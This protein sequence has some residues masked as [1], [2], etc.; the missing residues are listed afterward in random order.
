MTNHVDRDLGQSAPNI[1]ALDASVLRSIDEAYGVRLR[2][3]NLLPSEVDVVASAADI[4]GNRYVVKISDPQFEESVRWQHRMLRRLASNPRLTVP[5][6]FDT[7]GGADIARLSDGRFIRLYSWIDGTI[8]ARLSSHSPLLL[9]DL[10]AAAAEIVNTLEGVA[11]ENGV[12]R[13]HV[14]DATRAASSVAANLSAV[15]DPEVRAN[16][17]TI[18]SWFDRWAANHLDD[19][20]RSVVHQDLNDHNVL[21]APD[22]SGRMR[23]SG[24]LDF[25][26]ALY[27]ATVGEVAVAV[28]YAMPR[29]TDP[30]AAAMH[31]VAGYTARRDLSDA[32]LAALYPLAAA[33]LCVNAVIW[34]ART[35][36]AD[37]PYGEDRRRHTLP[38][39]RRVAAIPPALAEA[40][41]RYAAGRG[42]SVS[43]S[44]GRAPH[45]Q[46]LSG[47]TVV[48]ADL[49]PGSGLFDCV[50]VGEDPD[51]AISEHLAVGQVSAGRH[52]TARFD[53]LGRRTTRAGETENIVLGV[54]IRAAADE[55]VSAPESGVVVDVGR[56]G[57]VIAH[58]QDTQQEFFSRWSG[59]STALSVGA[60]LRAGD[61]L[62]RA[63][64]EKVTVALFRDRELA[65]LAPTL[66][67][68]SMLEVWHQVSPDPSPWLSIER[69]AEAA[70]DC[71][72]IVTVRREHFAASQR[73]YYEDPINIVRGSG[74]LMIDELGRTYLDAI[75]NVTHVGH[76]NPAVSRAI[77]RQSRRLNTNSRFVYASLARYA[78][79]LTRLLPEPL[80]CVF[81]VCTG[82]EANDLALRIARQVTGR[83]HVMV[84]DGAYHGNTTAVTGI[85]PNRYKGSGGSGPPPTTHEVAM[86]DRYRGPYRYDDARAAER[87][88]RDVERVAGDL[89]KHG[90]PPAAFIAESLMGTAGTIVYPDGYLASAFAAARKQG[91]L[92]ISDEV[93]VG[94]GRTGETFWCF[95]RQGVVPDIV[96][97]GKSIGNGHPIAAVVTSRE[98][99][100]AFDQ[101]MK[102]FN[103]FG[104]NP[105]SC[106]V[107]MAVLDEI[108]GRGLQDHA[109]EVGLYFKE[110]LVE[111]QRSH[112]VIG[113]VRGKGL[114]L[115]LDLTTDPATREPDPE[116]AKR[117][118]EQMKDEG[119][120]VI[121]TG[122]HDNVLKLK[123]PMVFS[124]RDVDL[125]CSVLDQVLTDRW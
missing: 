46:I 38:A 29:R 27:T 92:C 18:M 41:L 58:A 111:L 86:P 47:N 84:V 99:A 115:G 72:R 79:R 68:P 104:G 123:P 82:S 87:Y 108:E 6:V 95:A 11:P 57:V 74:T 51:T 77:T 101:G 32:E 22:R 7:V 37:N 66:V 50:D 36:A 103:T 5:R 55:I 64:E 31:V 33:R 106:E 100:Q 39:L 14:W 114:Y 110:R 119:V 73:N 53:L 76:A 80:E 54:D 120:I 113:D 24:I 16:V 122:V 102:Y 25:S 65:I 83:E 90:S 12:P 91:A 8:L 61:I 43:R 94:F 121:P 81:L 88:A 78:E 35:Q 9:R 71:E 67:A 85:S 21:A 40:A 30:L 60:V 44:V 59:L 89:Q 117:V 42:T 62:G 1:E 19:L 69:P 28:A 75:N 45:P 56:R 4:D 93:Q 26:D 23:V 124:R 17:A 13:S 70:W 63:V 97:M 112:A 3:T 109:L 52:L 2:Q 105:V 125:F 10:G 49:S 34:T 48:D 107:G 15:T 118:C 98:I 96:T 20:P 116:L